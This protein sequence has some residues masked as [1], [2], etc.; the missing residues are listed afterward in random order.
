[1]EAELENRWRS[2][3]RKKNLTPNQLKVFVQEMEERITIPHDWNVRALA[4]FRKERLEVQERYHIGIGQTDIHCALCGRPWGYGR[5]TCQ[6]ERL[7]KLRE[8]AKKGLQEEVTLS[9]GD[10]KGISLHSAA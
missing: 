10:S 5:H 6:E 9:L 8:R 7:E 3:Q 4:S 1:M 2:A